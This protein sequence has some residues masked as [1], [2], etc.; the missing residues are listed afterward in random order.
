MEWFSTA[1][2]DRV[3]QRNKT[4]GHFSTTKHDPRSFFSGVIIRRYTG[5][6]LMPLILVLGKIIL[7]SDGAIIRYSI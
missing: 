6:K 1:K 7:A 3:F 5:S 4:P 2:N